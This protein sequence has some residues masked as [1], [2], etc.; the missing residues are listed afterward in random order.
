[1]LR[2]VRLEIK[3]GIIME[4]KKLILFFWVF[5]DITS[6][7]PVV[8]PLEFLNL[9]LFATDLPVT[10]FPPTSFQLCLLLFFSLAL[11]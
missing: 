11:Y 3:R 9:W 8:F 10:F 4:P 7:A 1:M 5:G 2:M 6:F